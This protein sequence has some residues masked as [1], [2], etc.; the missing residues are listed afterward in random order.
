MPTSHQE[1]LELH[2]IGELAPDVDNKKEFHQSRRKGARRSLWE[3]G[4]IGSRLSS[5]HGK[6]QREKSSHPFRVVGDHDGPLG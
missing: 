3:P 4:E 1:Q 2:M 5:N 6:V